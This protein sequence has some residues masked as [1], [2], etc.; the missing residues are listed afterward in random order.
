MIRRLLRQTRTIPFNMFDHESYGLAARNARILERVYHKGNAQ[1]WDGKE[2]LQSLVDTHGLPKLDTVQREALGRVFGII[3]WGE[4]AAWRIS[5]ELADEIEP[6]EA[7]MA[8]TS[9]AFDEARHFYVMHD[10]LSLLNEVPKSIHWGAKRLLIE[11]MNANT[12]P[13]KLLGMQLMVEPVALT[14]FHIIKKLDIEPVLSHLMPYYERDESRHIALGIQYLPAMLSKMSHAERLNLWMF[15]FE[16]ITYEIMSNYA[17]M[18]DLA[19]LGVEPYELINAGK[20]KQM[21]ALQM[22]FE[23]IGIEDTL[24]TQIIDRYA[25]TLTELTIPSTD[26]DIGLRERLQRTL[27]VLRNGRDALEEDDFVPTIHDADTPL[28][29]SVGHAA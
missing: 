10:Y 16:L 15:Q 24:P 17:I 27:H 19:V 12:L 13:K 1:S 5:A 22:V 3:M 20:S 18:R 7:K 9:Q 8:A 11:V 23:S 6:L 21:R 4:L 26:H 2:V 28:I 29:R 25:D 14:L